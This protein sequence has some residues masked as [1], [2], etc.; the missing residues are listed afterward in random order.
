MNQTQISTRWEPA[1]HFHCSDKPIPAK[2]HN[3]TAV[4]A[5]QIDYIPGSSSANDTFRLQ[6]RLPAAAIGMVVEI[7]GNWG[8]NSTCLYPVAIYG[9]PH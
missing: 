9:H 8:G 1:T 2:Y 6:Y 3:V 5:A 4:L 7:V